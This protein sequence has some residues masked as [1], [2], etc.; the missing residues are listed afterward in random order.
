MDLPMV[1][2]QAYRPKREFI[3]CI[4]HKSMREGDIY[5]KTNDRIMQILR[6]K[7]RRGLMMFDSPKSRN[8][9]TEVFK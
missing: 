9:F 3:Y 7:W 5:V 4:D 1:T 8:T 6:N 2:V